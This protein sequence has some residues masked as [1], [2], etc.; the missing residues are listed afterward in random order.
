MIPVF[1]IGGMS[2]LYI[3]IVVIVIFGTLHL[4]ATAHPQSAFTKVWVG[5]LGF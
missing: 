3:A 5:A 4:L 1:R 2:V